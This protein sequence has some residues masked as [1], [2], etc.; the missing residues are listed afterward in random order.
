[1]V[2][3]YSLLIE[4][5]LTS[6]KAKIYSYFIIFIGLVLAVYAFYRYISDID[7]Q[8]LALEIQQMVCLIILCVL[9]RS[10]PINIGDGQHALDVSVVSILA[11]VIA[12][13]PYAAMCV[14][15]ISSLFTVDFNKETKT[16]HHLYNTSFHKSAFNNSNL[17]ISIL[18]PSLL[19][20][21]AGG[22]P[23][24][25]AL[26]GVIWP[27]F[28]FSISTFFINYVILLI[29]FILEKQIGMD[30]AADMIRSLLPNVLFAMP[31]GLL[32]AI[33]FMMQNG[34]WLAILMLFPLLL[35]RY[36]WSL[37]LESQV[38]HMKLI[39]AFVSAMEAK[40]TYTEGHSRR[41]EMFALQI[42][43]ELKLPK[44]KVKEIQIAALLH[45]IGKIGIE[46]I[47][48]RKPAKL[49]DEERLRIEEHPTIGVSIVEKVG[50]SEEIK[51]MIRHHH[52]RYDGK[53][54][55]DRLDHTEVS[56]E[57]YILGVADAFDAMTSD[58]PY[59]AGMSEEKALS[60]LTEESG[61]QF[62]PAVVET[63]KKLLLNQKAQ[64]KE[65][66]IEA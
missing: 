9:C 3:L 6:K 24:V 32:I 62:H 10:L 48:L 40:D 53:G 19:Y 42:A 50:L 5:I 39:H 4:V 16:Y 25:A 63:L 52:E 29:V 61:K 41:V 21:L 58:R 45:D 13:G 18:V 15:L 56:F 66:A 28:L 59:R 46:D 2:L 12:K 36:A 14:Y 54:Y 64:A 38:Q 57:A 26:P 27:A 43:A 20:K 1:M 8:N 47:I 35:A 23:G 22:T 34:H 55:P 33:L 60:I 49:T 65:Q 11:A 44:E 37:Y 7:H 51:E 17:M 31:L 30:D